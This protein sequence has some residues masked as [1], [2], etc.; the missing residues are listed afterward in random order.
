MIFILLQNKIVQVIIII[1]VCCF[2]INILSDFT[3]KIRILFINIR[4]FISYFP[5][6]F[7]KLITLLLKFLLSILF[8]PFTIYKFIKKYVFLNSLSINNSHFKYKKSYTDEVLY[9]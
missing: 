7:I 6:K 8:F 3:E 5:K 2:A 4:L 1:I 9:D